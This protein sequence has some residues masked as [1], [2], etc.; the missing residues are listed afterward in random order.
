MPFEL[1]PPD[2]NIDF[3]GKRY[4]CLVVSVLVILA[5]VIA[6]PMRG[7]RLGIDF[8]GGT[9]VQVRFA[10]GVPVEE[11]AIRKVVDDCGVV[12]ASVVRFGD[13][14]ATDYLIRFRAGAAS[15]QAPES[16]S[17]PLSPENVKQ[18]E[19][20]RQASEGPER[21]HPRPD[22]APEARARQQHRRT[23]RRARRVRGP[24]RREAICAAPRSTPL[25]SRRC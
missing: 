21:R 7:I 4:I 17:C 22:R 14:G 23:Q 8:A 13:L 3:I 12:D 6:I 19:A 25:A 11:G 15:E 18:L 16:G 5:G 2:T 24:A 20:E 9:E 10:E 1:I